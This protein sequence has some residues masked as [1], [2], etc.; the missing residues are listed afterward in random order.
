MFS[1]LITISGLSHKH[2]SSNSTSTNYNK[3]NKFD[4]KYTVNWI[5]ATANMGAPSIWYIL[6]AVLIFLNQTSLTK[7]IE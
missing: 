2:A 5:H 6:W 7:V 3:N 4:Y 1:T